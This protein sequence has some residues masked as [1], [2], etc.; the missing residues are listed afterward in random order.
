MHRYDQIMADID[1]GMTDEELAEL[2]YKE[3]QINSGS[4]YRQAVASMH[5]YRLVHDHCT[6]I[7][8]TERHAGP[9]AWRGLAI[10]DLLKQITGRGV[11]R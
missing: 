8:E 7:N 9:I 1:A 11:L 10:N 6:T 5:V 4:A 2:Y 3:N